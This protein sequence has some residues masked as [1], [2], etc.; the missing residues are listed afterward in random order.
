MDE[1]R[2]ARPAGRR[3]LSPAGLAPLCVLLISTALVVLALQT[4]TGVTYLGGT[5]YETEFANPTWWM[6]GFFLFLPIY[7]VSYR[8]PKHAAISVVAALVPQFVLPT[9]VVH[10]YVDGGWGDG[11]ESLGYVAPIL[12]T[13]MFAATAAFAA[14]HGRRNR[15]FQDS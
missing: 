4:A 15:R 10:R 7:L 1:Q 14:W 6:A 9:V 13:P 12:M 5:S 3:N 2:P 11:L 8:Y